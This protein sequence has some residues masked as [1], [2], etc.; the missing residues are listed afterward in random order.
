MSAPFEKVVAALQAHGCRPKVRGL[1]ASAHCLVHD[2]STPSLELDV[3]DDGRALLHCFAGCE[4]KVI[5]SLLD[6]EMSDLFVSALPH[7]TD[8]YRGPTKKRAPAGPQDIKFAVVPRCLPETMDPYC[9]TLYTY[10]DAVQGDGSRCPH[11]DQYLA[12]VLGWTAATVRK[13]G[14]HLAGAGWVSIDKARIQSATATQRGYSYQATAYA[15]IHNPIRRHI[16]PGATTPL[17]KARARPK[18]RGRDIAERTTTTVTHEMND[19][20]RSRTTVA[21]QMRDVRHDTPAVEVEHSVREV[22]VGVGRETRD[23]LGT[24]KGDREKSHSSAFFDELDPDDD[25]VD[26]SEEVL[27]NAPLI[28]APPIDDATLVFAEDMKDHPPDALFAGEDEAIVTDACSVCGAPPTRRGSFG[29][30][31][32]EHQLDRLVKA[33]SA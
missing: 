14:E 6:L 4:T 5:V 8:R 9:V 22:A 20:P 13:H 23:A 25:V 21:R 24:Q 27:D 16:N 18:P 11:G 33:P 30:L 32:C 2:D 10:L 26:A 28:T 3:G 7:A 31:V 29:W 12:D 15:V 1:H 19:A 17:R